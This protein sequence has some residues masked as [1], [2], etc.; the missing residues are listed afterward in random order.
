MSDFIIKK[1]ISI[2]GEIKNENSLFDIV[3]QNKQINLKDNEENTEGN[4][5]G[6]NGEHNE[7]NNNFPDDVSTTM[8]IPKGTQ[9]Y[10]ATFDIE[11]ISLENIKLTETLTAFFTPNEKYAFEMIASCTKFSHNEKE[12]KDEIK[13][14]EPNGFIHKFIVQEDI[15]NILKLNLNELETNEKI[16]K[17]NYCGIPESKKDMRYNGVAWL[18]T[19]DNNKDTDKS[20]IALCDPQRWLVKDGVSGYVNKQKCIAPGKLSNP[21]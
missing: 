8:I 5:E 1:K 18:N 16:V 14:K 13:N 10:H 7:E 20:Y 21:Y 12:T 6:N 17:S 2:G 15:P 9:L 11:I 3:F 4:N 19:Y